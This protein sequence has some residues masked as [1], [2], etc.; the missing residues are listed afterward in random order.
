M[1]AKIY[2]FLIGAL[3]IAPLCNKVFAQISFPNGNVLNLNTTNGFLY[4]ETRVF[5]HTGN[6]KSD[7]Y[8]WNKISDS[9][10]SNWLVTACFNG[11]CKDDLVQSGNFIKDYGLN[12][13]TCFIAFH[14]ETHGY[15]GTSVIKYKVFNKNNIA[16]SAHLIFNI[17][18]M[19]ATGINEL[20]QND[21][22]FYPSPAINNLTIQTKTDLQNTDVK[23]L[24]VLGGIQFEKTISFFGNKTQLDISNLIQGVYF[25]VIKANDKLVIRKFIKQ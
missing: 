18:Y 1:K 15:N 8:A 11:D 24:N 13:T 20:I 7:D 6:F 2:T 3:L 4:L 10:D 22:D 17:T 19:N 25:I 9:L 16:D 14:V 23:V 21:F 5:F 12:D